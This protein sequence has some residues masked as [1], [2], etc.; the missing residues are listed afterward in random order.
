[1]EGEILASE[2]KWSEASAALSEA[3]KRQPIPALAASTYVALVN[4]GKTS[5]AKALA[6]RW[7]REHP[8]D[9][10]V[11]DVIA[12]QAMARKDYTAAIAQYR[13]ILAINPEN[14]VALN[15]LAWMMSEA[16]DPKGREFAERAYHLAPFNASVVDTLGWTLF[17][18]GDAA[19]GTQLLRLAT[20]LAPNDPE[21][22]LHYAEALTKGGDK[23]GAKRVL[24]T[25]LSQPLGSLSRV[26][27]EKIVNAK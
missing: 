8:A 7:A 25:L 3:L 9:T 14:A 2:K 15:N 23:E 19:R 16:G 26:Q 24:A 17:K 5:E 1:M 27:A 4:A 21:I 12:Q 6:D 10:A 13:A 18:T 11:A 20:N 22:R